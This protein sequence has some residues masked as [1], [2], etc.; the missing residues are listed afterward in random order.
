MVQPTLP[1]EV[2]EE[3]ARFFMENGKNVKRAAE[4]AR[5]N[6]STFTSRLRRAREMGI[7]TEQTATAAKVVDHPTVILQP[8]SY[9]H[10]PL[11]TTPY[12]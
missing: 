3:T 9:T 10:L 6:Y 5:V 1:R 7:V 4:Q 2:Y 8:V 11:P 12:V